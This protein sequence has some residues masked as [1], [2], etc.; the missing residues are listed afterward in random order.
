MSSENGYVTREQ[1]ITPTPRQY[2]DIY[3]EG[4]GKVEIQTITELERS[5]MEA[6]NYPKKGTVNVDK[7]GD[8]RCR[9]VVVGLSKPQL[10]MAD[11][12]YLRQKD[13]RIINELADEIGRHCGISQADMEELEKN[14]EPTPAGGSP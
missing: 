12:Q 6:P 1:M 10:T 13:S 3:I 9:L 4:L 8:A 2:K 5:R 14:F 7:L 11:V